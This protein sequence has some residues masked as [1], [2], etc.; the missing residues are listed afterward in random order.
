MI[1][2]SRQGSDYRSRG[3]TVAIMAQPTCYISYDS[4][5]PTGGGGTCTAGSWN[6]PDMNTA[7][8][9]CWFLTFDDAN[10]EVDLQPG[11]Y[12][13]DGSAEHYATDSTILRVYNVTDSTTEIVGAPVYIRSANID[14]LSSNI[15]GQFTI[16]SLKSVRLEGRCQTSSSNGFGYQGTDF[17]VNNQYRLQSITKVK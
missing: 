16:S 1:Q 7:S 3:S 10:N 2:V 6:I 13:W 15:K 8:G 14:S 17:G 4:G 11:T 9:D 5:S 12:K